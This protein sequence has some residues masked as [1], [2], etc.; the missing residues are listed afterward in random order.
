MDISS[1]LESTVAKAAVNTAHMNGF[2]PEAAIRADIEKAQ[3]AAAVG[4]TEAYA[5]EVFKRAA[6]PPRFASRTL[7]NFIPHCDKSSRALRVAT[8]YAQNFKEVLEK[9]QSMIFVGNVGSGKTHLAS[10]IAHEVIQQGHQALFSTVL[11]AVRTV[12]ETYRRDSTKTESEAILELIEPDLLVLDEVG[13]QF[14]SDAEKLILFE[15]INGRYEHMKPTILLSN[16]NIE[17]LGEYLGER[18]M[19]RLREGGGKMIAFDW[20]SYRRNV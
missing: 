20:E 16:L 19:D 18:V 14:G 15:I 10:G 6:I 3:R 4:R 17:G 5:Q 8:S 7:G 12:K 9:G 1:L 13:V 11:G 2:D